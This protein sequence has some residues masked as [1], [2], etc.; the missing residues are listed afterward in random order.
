MIIPHSRPTIDQSD[1][2]A[3][4]DVLASGHIAQGEKVKE[5][6][7]A[8]AEFVGVKYAVACSSGTSA[9]HLALL[10]LGLGKGDEVI[11]PSYV[12]ASPYLATA[13]TGGVPKIAD[14]DVEDLNISAE[15]VKPL[16]SRKTKAIIVP[17]MFG[18]PAEINELLD[19]GVPVIED[20]AQSLGAEYHG[21]RVGSFGGLSMFSFYATKMIT[22]GEG[23]MVL[24]DDHDLY[25]KVVE[26]R[27]YDNKPL[28]PL[29]YNYKMTD[30]QAALGLSQ[31]SRL[32]AFIERRRNLASLY[33]A[34]LAKY[35]V[36][37]QKHRQGSVF[38]R[39]VIL[40]D[41]LL[42]VQKRF[43]EAGLMCEKPVFRP[44][45]KSSSVDE[46]PNCDWAFEH[47]LSVPIYPSLTDEEVNYILE[48]LSS[49]LSNT[50]VE[51]CGH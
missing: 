23:G 45:N 11:M 7:K 12:C 24:I 50:Q 16:I 44:L 39:Y 14:I 33:S 25:A 42:S 27:D 40:I 2:Q 49:I 41:D 48:T 1:I 18:N 47:A 9:L 5:F 38:Y 8:V 21:R 29:R 6:E 13:H 15:T 43:K 20:C 26:M 34:R 19:L 4:S 35:G 51:P 36:R 17:H 37:A 28:N 31:M 30:F 32:S 10:S 3:V 46:C 22:T